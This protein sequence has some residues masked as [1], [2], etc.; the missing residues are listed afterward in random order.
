MKWDDLQTLSYVGNT[1]SVNGKDYTV[2]TKLETSINA[3]QFHRGNDYVLEELA[4]GKHEKALLSKYDFLLEEIEIAIAKMNAPTSYHVWDES[5]HDF[6]EDLELCKEY[7]KEELN[8]AC[9]KAI[10][11]GFPSFALGTIHIYESEKEDQLNL[12]GLKD[13]GTTKPLKCSSDNKKTWEWKEHTPEQIKEV[14]DDG[15]DFKLNQLVKVSQLKNKVETATTI[16]KVL[17]NKWS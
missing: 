13:R 5:I 16:V 10:T 6:K 2:S 8:K 7:Q 14:F 15:V 4:M 17:E 11:S 12:T 1:V 3:V 9:E